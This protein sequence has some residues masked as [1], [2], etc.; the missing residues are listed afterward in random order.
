VKYFAIYQNNSR[1]SD[2]GAFTGEMTSIH[3]NMS[4]VGNRW[5]EGKRINENYEEE[6]FGFLYDS[7][8]ESDSESEDSSVEE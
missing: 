3:L 5:F 2:Q 8:L 6:A 7:S 1:W 4:Q